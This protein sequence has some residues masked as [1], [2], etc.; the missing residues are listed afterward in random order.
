[1]SAEP[2]VYIID[3]DD[4]VRNSLSMVLES[5]QLKTRTFGS[6][7]EFLA[8]YKQGEPGCI[9]MDIRMPDISGLELFEK[10]REIKVRLPVIFIT[11]Y[12]D[13]PTAVQAIRLGAMDFIEKPFDVN[14]LIARVYDC[15]KESHYVRDDDHKPEQC[16]KVNLLTPRERQV[17]ELMVEGK[18]NK[19]IA[20]DLGISVRTVEAHRAN[21]M[22]KLEANSLSDVVRI[23]IASKQ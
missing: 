12:G 21:L 6:A 5:E 22:D 20:N 14:E 3:D 1:M 13:V 8:K 9:L 17:M 2:V 18:I 4:G 7:T 16:K 10:L 11:G 19:V 15:I 23:A